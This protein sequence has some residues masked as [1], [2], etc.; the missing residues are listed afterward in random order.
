[1]NLSNIDCDKPLNFL[2]HDG[3]TVI[4]N[5]MPN[6]V[7]IDPTATMEMARRISS[8]EGAWNFLKGDKGFMALFSCVYNAEAFR[9]MGADIPLT[10]YPEGVQHITGLIVMVKEAQATGKRAFIRLPE[11]YLHPR[12]Q[13]GLGDLFISLSRV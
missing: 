8:E 4:R 3:T 1:M 9:S 7:T 10:D 6:T 12:Q 11:T 5:D 2:C 13:V